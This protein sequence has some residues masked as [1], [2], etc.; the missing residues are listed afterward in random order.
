MSSS[1]SLP[2]RCGFARKPCSRISARELPTQPS[3]S[4]ET[5]AQVRKAYKK[6]PAPA[7]VP[8]PL[9]LREN[10]CRG[11]ELRSPRYS[12]GPLSHLPW[13]REETRSQESASSNGIPRR[14]ILEGRRVLA[15]PRLQYRFRLINLTSG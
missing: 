13:L 6:Q 11:G 14:G 4:R 12:L 2:S 9:Q 7:H 8:G 1:R 10:I 3:E 5:Q 15:R